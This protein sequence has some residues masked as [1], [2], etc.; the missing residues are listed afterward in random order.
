LFAAFAAEQKLQQLPRMI[1]VLLPQPSRKRFSFDQ[2]LRHTSSF[3]PEQTSPT[4]EV[5]RLIG[6]SSDSVLDSDFGQVWGRLNFS[7]ELTDLYRYQT[8]LH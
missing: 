2:L 7:S 6:R 3:R 5:F 1:P 4:T 8:M